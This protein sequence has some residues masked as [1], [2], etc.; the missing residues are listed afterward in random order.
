MAFTDPDVQQV[1]TDELRLLDPSVRR[2]P[3]AAGALLDPEFREFGA[4]GRVWDRGSVLTMLSSD[5]APPPLVDRICGTRLAP[6][7]VLLTYRS[8][9][10]DR[11]TLRSS[12]WRRRDDSPWRIYFHQGTVVPA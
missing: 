10:A 8:R 3:T 2:S 6:D 5:D 1:V 12:L 7:V 11:T 9:T 4:S